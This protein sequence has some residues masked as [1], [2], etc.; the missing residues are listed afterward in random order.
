MSRIAHR[1]AIGGWVLDLAQRR[2]IMKPEG[3]SAMKTLLVS[4]CAL[5][6]LGLAGCASA[7]LAR[8]DVDGKLV[9]NSDYMDQVERSARLHMAEVHWVNCPQVKLKVV[10]S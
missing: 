2:K 5:S 10:D 6:V 9:C 8:A 1:A 7:P 4:V 3:G